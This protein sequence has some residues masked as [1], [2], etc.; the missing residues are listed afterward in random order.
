MMTHVNV[1]NR[2]EEGNPKPVPADAKIRA[3]GGGGE[4]DTSSNT[5]Y[6]DQYA[7]GDTTAL[8]AAAS[9]ASEH[10]RLFRAGEGNRNPDTSAHTTVQTRTT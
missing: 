8:T 2:W 4:P 7:G 5:V 3:R 6:V 1:V 9:L 10:V